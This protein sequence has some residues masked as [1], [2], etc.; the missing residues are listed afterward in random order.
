MATRTLQLISSRNSP[1][2]RAHFAIFVPSAANPDSGTLIQVVGAPM[3]GYMLEF[4]RNYSPTMT[5]E[6]HE[7]YPIGEVFAD[8]IL[9]ST[10]SGCRI[11]NKPRDKLAFEA[12]KVPPPRIS[13]NFRAPVN[14]VSESIIGC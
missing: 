3:V 14:N 8:N 12:A 6:P 11:D 9:E 1:K 13:E 5:Q 4:K 7:I 10:D 2:Q